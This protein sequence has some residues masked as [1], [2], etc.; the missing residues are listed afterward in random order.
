MKFPVATNIKAAPRSPCGHRLGG[1][2]VCGSAPSDVSG[3]VD[4]CSF[5]ASREGRGGPPP[6]GVAR[7]VQRRGEALV[8][9]GGKRGARAGG[10]GCGSR[11]AG[12]SLREKAGCG[13]T[14]LL[15]CPIG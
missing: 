8:D 10:R 12:S 4:A 5:V 6:G 11:A 15:T 14:L 7:P 1:T 3:H 2:H 13:P 9:R